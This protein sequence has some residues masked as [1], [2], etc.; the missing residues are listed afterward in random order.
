MGESGAG[1]AEHRPVLLDA[2][3]GLEDV[4]VEE[5]AL[6]G[7]DRAEGGVEHVFAVLARVGVGGQVVDARLQL[8]GDALVVAIDLV[9]V[10]ELGALQ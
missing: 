10:E 9:V 8:G 5:V 4:A 3:D 2:V 7:V 6:L 1:V